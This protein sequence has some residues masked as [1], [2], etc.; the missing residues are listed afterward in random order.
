MTIDTQK[1]REAAANAKDL[2]AEDL[3]GFRLTATA[4]ITGLARA[5][6]SCCDHIDAQAAEIDGAR[7]TIERWKA[8]LVDAKRDLDA[9]KR[10]ISDYIRIGNEQA[11]EI[12][13]LREALNEAVR[14]LESAR[15][16]CNWPSMNE[17]ID[18]SARAGR[19]ALSGESND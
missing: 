2:T 16:L 4:H 6:E 5:I 12:G 11:A 1:L 14:V 19:A 9:L 13:R 3:I 8:R 7:Q 18:A 17:A 10:D 15:L